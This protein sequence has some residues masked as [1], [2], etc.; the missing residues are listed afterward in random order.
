M[1]KKMNIYLVYFLS[2]VVGYFLGSI[3]SALFIGKVFFKKDVREMGSGN[4]GA[5]N[6]AR[7]LGALPGFF[8]LLF[9]FLK[10]LLATYGMYFFAKYL[11]V[12]AKYLPFIFCLTGIATCIGHCY[13]IFANFKG[14]KCVSVICGFV[15]GSNWILTLIGF[16]LFVVIMLWKKIVSLSSICMAFFTSIIAF[17]LPFAKHGSYFLEYT[18]IYPICLSIMALILIL[19]HYP[20]IQKLLRHEEKIFTFKKRN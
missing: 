6:V 15:I 16:S 10:V 1:V 20:N 8:T 11:Q 19:R 12:E 14:G 5:T 17:I 3:P 9:D 7:T 4:L 18:I 2:I 13:P